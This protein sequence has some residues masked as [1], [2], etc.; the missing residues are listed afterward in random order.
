[1]NIASQ[2]SLF[3]AVAAGAAAGR[4]SAAA[5]L[6]QIEARMRQAERR[7][8][9]ERRE[10][11]NGHLFWAL[12]R[13]LQPLY[14][15]RLRE[16]TD[17]YF[18]ARRA[19]LSPVLGSQADEAMHGWLNPTPRTVNIVGGIA[20]ATTILQ[21]LGDGPPYSSGPFHQ[22]LAVDD[23]ATGDVVWRSVAP[24]WQDGSLRKA[25]SKDRRAVSR[26]SDAVV[27]LLEPQQAERLYLHRKSFRVVGP[28]WIPWCD[29]LPS[30]AP[31]GT[32]VVRPGLLPD[33]D[34]AVADLAAWYRSA[35][36]SGRRWVCPHGWTHHPR[37][38]DRTEPH[39][40]HRRHREE[41]CDRCCMLA[42]PYTPKAA[43]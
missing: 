25:S 9:S 8:D 4:S 28:T 30:G 37:R 15:D 39:S 42:H 18:D 10:L 5:F 31:T 23:P 6:A 14:V 29:K 41:P 11:L 38:G 40:C 36:K 35:L 21:L 3:D 17:Y 16:A 22:V 7:S 33:H 27:T 20:E 32:L 26:A 19:E 1:M 13:A 12:V 43:Q 24:W 2:P 34:D